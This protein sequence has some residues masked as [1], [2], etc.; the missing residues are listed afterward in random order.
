MTTNLPEY[1]RPVQLAARIRRLSDPLAAMGQRS[2]TDRLRAERDARRW[3]AIATLGAFL[4]LTGAIANGVLSPPEPVSGPI[5]IIDG[6]NRA[7]DIR[8]GGS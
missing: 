4:G 1:D 2:A 7:A 8:T 3:L 5:V 6:G